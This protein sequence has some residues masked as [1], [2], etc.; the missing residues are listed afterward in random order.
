M[1]LEKSPAKKPDGGILLLSLSVEN[2]HGGD[3]AYKALLRPAN[4]LTTTLQYGCTTRIY[5]L[6]LH[7]RDDRDA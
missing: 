6:G 2:K 3:G 7:R 5:P 4:V 1:E